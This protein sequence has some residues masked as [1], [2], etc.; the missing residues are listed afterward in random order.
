MKIE[1]LNLPKEVMHRHD[2]C[3]KRLKNLWENDEQF[4]ENF[5]GYFE[6]YKNKFAKIFAKSSLR[7]EF[8]EKFF[9]YVTDLFYQGYYLG[10]ELLEHDE[11]TIED[12]FFAQTDGVIREQVYD[13]LKGAAGDLVQL[14]SHKESADFE[15]WVLE[16]DDSAQPILLQTKVD[17]ACLG[18]YQC[19]LDE[20]KSR[21]IHVISEPEG[22]IQGIVARS[23]ELFFV[24]PQKFLACLFT[25][26]H[27][28]LWDIY[29][30]ATV[31]TRNKKV[32]EV[33]VSYFK[34]EVTNK[35]VEVLPFYRGL[36]AMKRE[37]GVVTI[38]LI[39]SSKVSERERFPIV[40]NIVQNV[41]KRLGL[42]YSNI[43]V[44]LCI[45]DDFQTY[46]F[47]PDNLKREE[48]L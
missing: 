33:H 47:N 16:Q 28:E 42:D 44:T 43:N 37:E 38:T 27:S 19:F 40:A 11:V 2:V 14:L 20:R 5:K 25:D 45:S 1:L 12:L 17:F 34:P 13:I 24:D 46:R 26:G 48:V 3:S 15:T 30:W 36:E 31:P 32:G 39:L 22:D 29:L 18:A 4:V 9:T 35:L 6:F 21:D 7:D 8:I 10:L 41:N 23:D